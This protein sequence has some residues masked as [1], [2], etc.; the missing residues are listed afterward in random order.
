MQKTKPAD[1]LLTAFRPGPAR[2]LDI[3]FLRICIFVPQA[4]YAYMRKRIRRHAMKRVVAF[5][6]LQ[7]S[8]ASGPGHRDPAGRCNPYPSPPFSWKNHRGSH[9]AK[10][11]MRLSPQAKRMT[12]LLVVRKLKRHLPGRH[13]DRQRPCRQHGR[14]RYAGRGEQ[15]SVEDMLKRSRLLRQRLLGV[16]RST[17]RPEAQARMNQRAAELGMK[18]LLYKLPGSWTTHSHHGLRRGLMSRSSYP[19]T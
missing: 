9:Y 7:L 19:T 10:T 14:R 2:D 1:F 12:L 6:Y 13:G 5:F 15:L 17:S 18:T 3:I 4:P 11:P 8:Y 16:W